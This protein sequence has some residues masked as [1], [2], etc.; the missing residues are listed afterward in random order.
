MSDLSDQYGI[1]GSENTALSC[2]KEKQR[3]LKEALF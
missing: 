3:V 1:S 2:Q